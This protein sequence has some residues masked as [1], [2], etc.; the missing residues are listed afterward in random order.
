MTG[1]ALTRRDLLR[2]G[3]LLGL[4]VTAGGTLTGCAGGDAT[5]AAVPGKPGGVLRVGATGGGV[6]DTLDPHNPVTYPD[7][8]RVLNLYEPLFQRNAKY[9]I[10]PLIGESLTP[11]ADAQ[12]WT[13][14]LRSGVEFHNG[15]T[16][17]A[18]D[19]IFSLRR[20]VDP[21]APGWP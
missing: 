7:Q 8:A 11:S 12:V 17:D 19:V 4:A 2:R 21:A 16:L 1:N 20:I 13:L 14:K 3:A 18:D 9:E 15:K 10:E 6:K 5:P